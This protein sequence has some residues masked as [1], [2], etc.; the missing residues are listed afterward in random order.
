MKRLLLLLLTIV[1][2]PCLGACNGKEETPASEPVAESY[3]LAMITDGGMIDDR[4]FNQRAWEGLVAYAE[5]N[6]ITKQYYKPTEQTSDAY[7]ASIK[8]AVNGGARVIVAPGCIFGKS[9]FTA[10]DLY[11]DI[12]FIILD[13]FPSDG[14]DP[15]TFKTNENVVGI[16]Y[17]EEQSGFLAG[18]AAVKEGY[19]KL[20]FMGGVPIPAVIKFGYGFAQG[21][22]AAAKEIGVDGIDLKY[23]YTMNFKATHGNQALAASWYADGTEVIFAAGGAVG[24]SVMSA[25]EAAGKYVIGVNVDQSDESPTVITSAM[26][27]LSAPLQKVL[28]DFYAD[29]FPGGEG[30][31]FDAAKNGIKL[32]MKTSRFEKFTQEDYDK[33]Y[34]E[35]A[36]GKIVI[37]KDVDAGSADQLGLTIV[38]VR[39]V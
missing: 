22:E 25:A 20:G 27:D 8:Q 17:A 15:P 5:K 12:S 32:P 6:D 14:D 28:A 3:E 24:N 26:K 33:I 35:M 4:S 13:A 10:Q 18:Y 36:A 34:K 38:K 2:I 31:V 37:K 11:P 39:V 1:M 23:H 19:T 21:A 30:F 29:K 9:I 7:L 16:V